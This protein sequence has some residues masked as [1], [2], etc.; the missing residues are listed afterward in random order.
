MFVGADWE[1]L[2]DPKLNADIGS[3]FTRLYKLTRLIVTRVRA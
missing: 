1:L 3:N 2:I